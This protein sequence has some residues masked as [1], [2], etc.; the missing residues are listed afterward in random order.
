MSKVLVLDE[1]NRPS[2][3]MEKNE[4]H[5]TKT[6]HR[7]FSVFLH[8]GEGHMLLQRRSPGKY[9]SGGLWTNA[10]CSHPLTEDIRREASLRLKEELGLEGI[11][12]EELY[13]RHYCLQVS[14]TMTENEYDTVFLGLCPRIPIQ[15]DPEE[16]DAI[17]WK[18]LSALRRDIRENKDAYTKWFLL[19]A[20]PVLEELE[21]RGYTF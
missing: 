13:S 21:K 3:F 15:P 18:E 20:E 6:R 17:E 11:E 12:L 10:C 19:L 16:A 7:A 9:H 14:E 1:E 8:D 5:L 2:G 4:A